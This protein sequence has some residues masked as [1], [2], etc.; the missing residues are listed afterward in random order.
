MACKATEH[1]LE[2]AKQHD[3]HL[4]AQQDHIAVRLG[5]AVGGLDA[6]GHERRHGNVYR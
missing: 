4:S 5:I 6:V 3:H 1:T 2:E